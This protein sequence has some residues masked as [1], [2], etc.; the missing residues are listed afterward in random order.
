MSVVKKL[1]QFFRYFFAL[2][3][4]LKNKV[5]VQ[6]YRYINLILAKYYFEVLSLVFLFKNT[7]FGI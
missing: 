2:R 1:S 4:Q 7:F 6:Y 3:L 5:V